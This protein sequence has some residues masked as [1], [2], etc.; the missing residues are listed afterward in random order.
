MLAVS[1]LQP[2]PE[3]APPCGI[4]ITIDNLEVIREAYGDLLAESLV[5][6]IVRPARAVLRRDDVITR[7]GGRFAIDLADAEAASAVHIAARIR[8]ALPRTVELR[9]L[10]TEVDASVEL[11]RR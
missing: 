8:N 5:D 1:Q 9:G 7:S 6:A 10:L 2:A 11:I 4:V 3:H